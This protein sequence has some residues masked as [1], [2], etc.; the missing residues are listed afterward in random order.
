ML[1]QASGDRE[2]LARKLKKSHFHSSDVFTNSKSEGEDYFS[3]AIPLCLSLIS[4]RYDSLSE[5]DYQAGRS[6]RVT[7]GKEAEKDFKEG[8]RQTMKRCFIVKRMRYL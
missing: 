7:Y 8:T 3:L 5:S 4:F 2:I 6:M 1:N